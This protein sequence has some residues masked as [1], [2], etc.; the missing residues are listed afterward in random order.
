MKTKK[1][2]AIKSLLATYL[3]SLSLTSISKLEMPK[4]EEPKPVE[5]SILLNSENEKT[6]RLVKHIRKH[7]DRYM[8]KTSSRLPQNIFIE[9]EDFNLKDKYTDEEIYDIEDEIEELLSIVKV[10]IT[11]SIRIDRL[12][13]DREESINK[14][15]NITD[16]YNENF[17]ENKKLDTF[18]K[19]KMG[20]LKKNIDNQ[21]EWINKINEDI[22]KARI[23]RTTVMDKKIIKSANKLNKMLPE[24]EWHKIINDKVNKLSAEL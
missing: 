17:P 1:T 8:K 16:E 9:E 7:Q 20:M 2:I 3:L 15:K 10:R 14:I 18:D 12:K 22:K 6:F 4:I 19:L 24:D 5:K 11:K 13:E 23:N 21:I